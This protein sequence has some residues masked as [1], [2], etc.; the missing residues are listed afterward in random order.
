VDVIV[1]PFLLHKDELSALVAEWVKRYR[2]YAPVLRG[3]ALRFDVVGSAQE[4]VLDYRNTPKSPKSVFLPQTECLIRFGRGRDDFNVV[5]SVPL[6][7]TPTILLGARPCDARSF[8]L[9]DK[10]FA[11]GTYLDPYYKAR[12]DNTLVIALACDHPRQTCFC[13]AFDSGPYDR[14]GSD[15]FLR[16][17]GDAYLVEAVSARGAQML[18]PL[19][20]AQA[21][22]THLDE[23]AETEG[24][25]LSRLRDIE[26]VAGIEIALPALFDSEVWAEI[27][28]KCLACGTCTYV[29]PTCHCFNIEDIVL[30]SGGDRVRAWD[31]CMYPA[32][33]M[34]ASG[35]NPRP[36][37]ASRWRQR[38][39]HKF[40]YLPR[41]TGR[42]GCVGC[43]RCITACP[44][45]LDI[46]HVLQRV[47]E[48]AAIKSGVGGREQG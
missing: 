5:A 30:A 8:L 34:Q 27:S 41:N 46:R 43:G 16:Q 28:E 37:Q 20:L 23:A 11:E 39:M 2:V 22:Q 7:D 42:Y 13:H 4:V 48:E 18:E 17:A 9:L 10:V 14:E 29:C 26:S 24:K 1:G 38:T 6:D 32:F 25:A 12:R 3:G 44:V 47:R 40:E 31:S 19:S 36:D 15:V 45:G 35:H 21:D 33:T